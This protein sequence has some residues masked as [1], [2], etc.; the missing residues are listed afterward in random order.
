MTQD[1]VE[2]EK[3]ETKGKEILLVNKSN[4]LMTSGFRYFWNEIEM[5]FVFGCGYLS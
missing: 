2:N 3:I 4:W 1:Y 5:A